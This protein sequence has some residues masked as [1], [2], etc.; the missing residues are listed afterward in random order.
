MRSTLRALGVA[1]HLAPTVA[2]TAVA[3][4]LA[5]DVGRGRSSLWVALAVLAGQLS[6]GWSNDA[7][8]A[9][10][11]RAAARS[12]KP[13]VAGEVSRQLVALCALFAL[14][15][16]VPLSLASGWRAATVH[17]VAV[18]LAWAY[19]LGLKATWASV[20]PYA[21][22]FALLPAFVTLGLAGSPWPKPVVMLV[23][24]L[25]GV[26]A[27]FLN[28]I[29]DADDDALTGVR[30]LPQRL[31]PEVS[32]RIGVVILGLAALGIGALALEGSGQ[33]HR[34]LT[35]LLVGSAL[36]VD[37]AVFLAARRDRG[38]AAWH[39]TLASA[40][41]CVLAFVTLGSSALLAST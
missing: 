14:V 6:V 36:L 1:C 25:L 34:P 32:L 15:L 29:A 16:C 18:A 8:D 21:V 40:G 31:G 19:N 4:A 28:T 39:G 7:L 17:L 5:L 10:R 37:V 27:H 33:P 3:T 30:G 23:A 41:L 22:S 2:V 12:A 9:A 38:R 26:G 24:G 35:L 11:D 13:I 20:V